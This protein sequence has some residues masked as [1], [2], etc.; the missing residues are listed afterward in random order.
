MGRALPVDATRPCV[1]REALGGSEKSVIGVAP[2][3]QHVGHHE[4]CFGN[5]ALGPIDAQ[6]VMT[7]V[8]NCQN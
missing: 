6:F 7:N 5:I 4:D 3:E 1:I 8:Q 2:H